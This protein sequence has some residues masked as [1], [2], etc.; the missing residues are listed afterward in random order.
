MRAL[1]TSLIALPFLILGPT[2]QAVPLAPGVLVEA[3][4]E[5]TPVLVHHKPGHHMKSRGRGRHLGWSRGRHK[6]WSKHRR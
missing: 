4:A 1:C 6:G 5:D 3:V 2:A